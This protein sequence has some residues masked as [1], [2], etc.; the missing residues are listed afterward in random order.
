M[1]GF[2]LRTIA[3]ALFL[4]IFGP[5]FVSQSA[6]AGGGRLFLSFCELCEEESR[7]RQYLGSTYPWPRYSYHQYRGKH[8]DARLSTGRYRRYE[9][10]RYQVKSYR[11]IHGEM[12]P[13]PE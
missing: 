4:G 12:L 5:N 7:G 3:F 2:Q 1:K 6:Q 8:C 10:D 13:L 11:P 9:Y